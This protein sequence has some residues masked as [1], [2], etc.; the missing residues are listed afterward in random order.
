MREQRKVPAIPWWLGRDPYSGKE[1]D[2]KGERPEHTR[3]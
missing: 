3:S 2:A 1:Y